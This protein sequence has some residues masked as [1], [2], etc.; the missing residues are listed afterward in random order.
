[1]CA[2]HLGLIQGVLAQ[3]RAPVTADQIK[4]FAEPGVCVADLSAGD[5]S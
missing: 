4:P 5:G 2:L 1:V 3:L